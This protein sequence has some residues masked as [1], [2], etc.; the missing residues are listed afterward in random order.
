MM[1]DEGPKG[2]GGPPGPAG[3]PGPPGDTGGFDA[4][5]LSQIF[6]N[7]NKGPSQADD[8]NSKIQGDKI[9][10]EE[11]LLRINRIKNEVV[12]RKNP[13][14][15]K[16]NPGRTC[17]D[18]A[19][20]HPDFK[21]GFYWIDPNMGTN[22]DAVQAWCNIEKKETCIFADPE[23]TDKK[24]WYR[25]PRKHM[26]FSADI[27]GG[28]MFSYKFDPVQMT[29]LKL[30]SKR[31]SQNVTYHCKNSIAYYD[32]RE[33]TYDKA[34]KLLTANDLELTAKGQANFRYTVQ[35]DGC[36]TKTSSWSKTVI[37][38]ETEKAERL[39][40]LDIAPYDL[41]RSNQAMGIDIG[42]VCFS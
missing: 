1:G 8:P 31:A 41:G 30:L 39:P 9:Q 36:K 42:P 15:E 7:Q 25:G 19:M 17:A 12:N 4:A 21:N 29:F 20:V 3:P 13:R 6:G 10:G 32:A 16:K 33:R 35:E 38:Y 34:V 28:A 11:V 14:G 18:I 37:S 40:I 22:N 24:S 26:W 2:Y 23:R 27:Q 5:Q